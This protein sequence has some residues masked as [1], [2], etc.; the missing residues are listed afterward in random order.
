MP[1]LS[2]AVADPNNVAPLWVGWPST[3]AWSSSGTQPSLGNGTWSHKYVTL[4][5]VTFASFEL[6]MGSTTTFGTG[7]YRF[8]VPATAVSY[9]LWVGSAFLYDD[10][11]ASNRRTGAVRFLDSTT[12][13]IYGSN[14]EISNTVPFTWATNDRIR[15][16]ITYETA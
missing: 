15:M 13:L 14:G 11:T 9:E 12:L 8:S 1:I 10:S 7:E 6:I 4:G 3:P 16:S 2:G 5:K